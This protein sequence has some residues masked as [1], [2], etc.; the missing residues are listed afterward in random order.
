MIEGTNSKPI[1]EYLRNAK[2]LKVLNMRD[3]LIRDEAGEAFMIALKGN[4]T[5][6]KF[7]IDMNPIKHSIYLEIDKINKRNQATLK[8]NQIPQIQEEISILRK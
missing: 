7:Q 4:L 6:T 3:N 8:E 2:N 5:L 1:C